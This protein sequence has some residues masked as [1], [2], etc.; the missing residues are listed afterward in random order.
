[1][2]TFNGLLKKMEGSIGDLTF[3]QVNGQTVVSQ[4]ITAIS[5]PRTEA[6]MRTRTRFTNIVSMYRGIRPLLNNGFEHRPAGCSDYNMFVCIN[7]QKEPVYLTK[8]QRSGG[9]CVAAPYQ[10]TQGSLPSIVTT[11]TSQNIATDISLGVDGIT[12]ATTVGQF[13]QSVV[14]NNADY[15]YGD[16][17]SFFLVKQKVNSETSIPYCQFFGWRVVLDA[18]NTEKLWDV[19]NRN[20]FSAQDGYLAHSGNDGDCVFTWVHSRKSNGKTLV[21]S[22]SL[23]DANSI[24]SQYQGELAFNLARSSYGE[25][26]SAFLTPDADATTDTG[27]SNSGNGGNNGGG[28]GNDSL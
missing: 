13:S 26:R 3:K 8:Q 17:I 19:V 23:I 5:N 14:S 21:S 16:Q 2:A 7:M 20:G 27:N 11:G 15:H 4:K 12:T 6:Q 9:A 22:Q 24:L 1:M 18:S 10:V 28:G 25:G